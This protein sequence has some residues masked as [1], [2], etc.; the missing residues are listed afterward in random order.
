MKKFRTRGVEKWKRKMKGCEK[1]GKA[2]KR[3][4]KG[5]ETSK[6]PQPCGKTSI[7]DA[8]K[9]GPVNVTPDHFGNNFGEHSGK[10]AIKNRVKIDAEKT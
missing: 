1:G 10:R 5:T 6:G 2:S 9:G 3:M 8:K 4:Q 7:F